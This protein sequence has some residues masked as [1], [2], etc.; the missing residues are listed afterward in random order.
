MLNSVRVGLFLAVRYITRSNIWA[1]MLIVA[2]MLLTFLNVVVVRGILV[3]LPVGAS[4]AYEEQFSGAVLISALPEKR[5]IEK[6]S[7]VEGIVVDAP[8]Y[9]MHTSRLI[10]GSRVEANYQGVRKAGEEPDSTAAE[11]VG[12]DPERED[13]VT[14]LAGKTLEG[15]Y[16]T[17][18]DHDGVLIGKN[19]LDRFAGFDQGETLEGVFPGEKVRI[20]IGE[21]TREFTVVGIIDSKVG[22]VSRRVFTLDTTVRNMAERFDT[23]VNEIAIR[24]DNTEPN[25]VVRDVILAGGV[26]AW[27][28]VE[29]A[30]DAQGQ[31]LDD[32]VNTFDVLSNVIGF[33]GLAVA[34]ITVFI[35]I[36]INAISRKRQIGILKG[37]GVRGIA[38]ELSYIFL[39][40]FYALIGI[41]L[42][43]LLL[44]YML[45]PY[46][47]ANPIDFPFSDGILVAPL[48][49]TLERSVWMILATLLAGYLPAR[50]IVRTN[51]INAILGR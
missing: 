3:G 14:G 38:I 32:I 4:I 34:A 15:R 45:Q 18:D 27:A 40:L 31:F 17:R 1:T 51:T 24:T 11:I 23:N 13:I 5:A 33:I 41:S 8:G 47:A 30:R 21:N 44:E 2:I 29:T 49:D 6:T 37:I 16:L 7:R 20:T 19:L 46:V 35:V 10:E 50:L 22:E 43:I 28:T 26:G 9:V 42:G 39:S 25:D 48:R 12:I 36:F